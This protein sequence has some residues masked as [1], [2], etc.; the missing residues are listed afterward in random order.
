MIRLFANA[1][2]DF[3]AWRTRAYVVTAIGLA[4]GLIGLVVFG[5]NAFEFTGGT[6]MQIETSQDRL[7]RTRCRGIHGAEIQPS[8]QP[9]T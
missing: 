8:A 7:V 5:V 3:I 9:G 6:L 4:I 2:Y 1:A